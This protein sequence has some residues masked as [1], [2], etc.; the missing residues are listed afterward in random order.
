MSGRKRSARSARSERSERSAASVVGPSQW[1]EADI[2]RRREY[3][4]PMW[5]YLRGH[6][7]SVAQVMEAARQLAEAGG[8]AVPGDARRWHWKVSKIRQG[9]SVA[10]PWLVQR[11]CEVIGKSVAE[12]MG[13][14]WVVRFG[15]DGR[16]GQDDAPV[17]EHRDG[18][19]WYAAYFPVPDAAVP[20]VPAADAVVA[21]AVAVEHTVDK[22][23]RS[24]IHAA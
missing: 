8:E 22:A 7:R 24:D 1:L 15:A 10:P 2:A 11:S 20:A 19:R 6:V 23:E 9:T 3:L 21:V 14:E 5:R 12:V 16:G 13:D 18:S 17:R 4:A